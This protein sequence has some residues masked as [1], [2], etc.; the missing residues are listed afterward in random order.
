MFTK[1]DDKYSFGRPFGVVEVDGNALYKWLKGFGLNPYFT[2]DVKADD[3]SV[4]VEFKLIINGGAAISQASVDEIEAE[5]FDQFRLF[6]AEAKT[7]P[8]TGFSVFILSS[9]SQFVILH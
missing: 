6:G 8:D 2:T 5:L 3:P 4:P 7:E 1:N 9:F